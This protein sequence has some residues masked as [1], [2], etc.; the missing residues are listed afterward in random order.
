MPMT[1]IPLLVHSK[2]T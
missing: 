1:R 2:Y